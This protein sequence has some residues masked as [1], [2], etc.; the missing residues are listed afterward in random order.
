MY[1]QLCFQSQYTFCKSGCRG[2]S[3]LQRLQA[4]LRYDCNDQ[5]ISVQENKS[6]SHYLKY[7]NDF[8]VSSAVKLWLVLVF[9]RWNSETAMYHATRFHLYEEFY[10]AEKGVRMAVEHIIELVSHKTIYPEITLQLHFIKENYQ[11]LMTVLTANEEKETSLACKAFNYL[12]DL[13]TYLRAVCEKT[14]FE[15]K[16]DRLL[17]KLPEPDRKE[18]I[19]YFQK[20]LTWPQKKHGGYLDK[21]PAYA[22]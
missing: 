15:T 14:T 12:E 19:N 11:R 13:K 1:Y 17:S 22:Y 20:T 6:K 3:P 16:T 5:I 18:Q 2:F 10:R 8:T 4:H 9:S 7:L 21:Y